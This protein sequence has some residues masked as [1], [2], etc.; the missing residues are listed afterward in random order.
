MFFLDINYTGKYSKCEFSTS[1]FFRMIILALKCS[2]TGFSVFVSN[3][4]NS[5]FGLKGFSAG[6]G[7]FAAH[8]SCKTADYAL[9]GRRHCAFTEHA[10]STEY[11][12]GA[13]INTGGATTNIPWPQLCVTLNLVGNPL[14]G[15][16]RNSA[17][18]HTNTHA[19]TYTHTLCDHRTEKYSS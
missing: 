18:A 1:V 12:Q 2:Q 16:Q 7:A 19:H 11:I 14:K 6:F 3:P 13:G 10:R 4:N 17:H 15:F 8:N 5:C 9:E